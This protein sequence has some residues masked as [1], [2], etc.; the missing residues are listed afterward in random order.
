[1]FSR[2][3]ENKCYFVSYPPYIVNNEHLFISPSQNH[4][5]LSL[6]SQRNRKLQ[7]YDVNTFCTK[8]NVTLSLKATDKIL[9]NLKQ[10]IIPAKMAK[11]FALLYFPITQMR[12]FD[13]QIRQAVAIKCSESTETRWFLCLEL[14][15]LIVV[16]DNVFAVS[17][18]IN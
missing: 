15:C 3:L 8:F 11:T 7:V 9:I 4:I 16:W 13:A 18:T 12:H 1:M 10:T 17:K 2:N 6:F 14:S 5:V